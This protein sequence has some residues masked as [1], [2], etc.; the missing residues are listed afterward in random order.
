MASVEDAQ[1]QAALQERD[2]YGEGAVDEVEYQFN[3]FIQASKMSI[4][5]IE[6]VLEID[7][8]MIRTLIERI[9]PLLLINFD[10]NYP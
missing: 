8:R 5:P 1:P 9:A 4:H 7:T 10:P 2:G 6:S 3:V